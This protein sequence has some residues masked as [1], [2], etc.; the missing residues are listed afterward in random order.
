MSY[1]LMANDVTE[2][3]NAQGI[4][5]T[6]LLGHSMG[7]K[8]A[9]C[10]ADT[11]P[12]RVLTL[13]V[14]D[15]APRDYPPSHREIIDALLALNIEAYGSRSEVERAL[16]PKIADKVVR[17]FL[18]KSITRNEHG[19]FHW[20]L[21]LP[22]IS[23]NYEQLSGALALSGSFQNAAL[24]VRAGE[25]DYINEE[26]FDLIRRDFPAAEIRTIAGVGH[27]LHAEAPEE[28]DKVLINFLPSGE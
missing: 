9:M 19:V 1:D 2:F 4:A 6:H 22:A 15:V 27:W 11:N 21:N 28:L 17:Q 3:M 16:E 25:S 26:D 8:T 24:F 12:D 20:K 7:G 23:A 10:L 14:L 5:A 18:L 13:I